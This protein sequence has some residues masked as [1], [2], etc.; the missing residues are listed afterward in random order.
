[1]EK[2]W[3]VIVVG[4]G[5]AGLSAA[6]VLGRCGRKVLVCDR[7]TPR[8]WASKA[9]HGFLTRDGTPPAEFGRPAREELERYP[10]VS[11]RTV[12]V[13]RA[14]RLNNGFTIQLGDESAWARKIL[15]ATGVLDQLP[16]IEGFAELFG[17]GVFQ[18]PYC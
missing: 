14:A 9:M 2:S 7:G 4:G 18:C 11:C 6:L 8:S 3:D 5:P 17:T 12:E 16:D 10:T 1:M 15:I 13:E